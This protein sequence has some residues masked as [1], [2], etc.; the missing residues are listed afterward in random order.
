MLGAYLLDM[1]RRQRRG[2]EG[3]QQ[4]AAYHNNRQRGLGVL[5]LQY[6]YGIQGSNGLVGYSTP[7]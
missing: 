5:E 6:G 3:S 1:Y 4:L 7:Q 2:I